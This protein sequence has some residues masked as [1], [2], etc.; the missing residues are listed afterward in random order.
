MM[1]PVLALCVSFALASPLHAAD[2]DWSRIYLGS[3][4]AVNADGSKFVFE[5]NDHL[6]IAPT[7]GGTARRLGTG[8]TYDSWPTMSPDGKRVAFASRRDGGTKVFEF[9]IEKGTVR[10][11]SYHS[12]TTWPRSWTPDG[13]RLLCLGYRDSSGPKTSL[14]VISIATGGREA[15]EILFDL[16]AEDPV[17]SP[18]GR[19]V[20]FV[21][22]GDELYR[23]RPNS[24]GPAAGQIWMFI[25]ATREFR[26]VVMHK[27]DCRNPLWR[28]DGRGFYYLDGRSG[29]RNVWYRD[30][31]TGEERALTKFAVDHVFQPSL[32]ADGRTMVFRQRF[33]FWRIDPTAAEP[34]PERILL[35]PEAG[36]IE[37]GKAKRRSYDSCWN[38]DSDGD[39]TFCDN[40]M[41]IAFTAGGDLYV[42]DTV[43]KEPTL[44][45]GD[46]ATHER[47]CVFAP[48]GKTLYYLSDRG[49]SS[50]VMKAIPADISKPW[51]E[52]SSF[53]KTPFVSTTGQRRMLS[54]SPDGSRLA[55][56]DPLGV[57]TFVDTNGTVLSRGPAATAG[58]G[59]AWSPDGRW[60]AAQLSDEFGNPDI[61]IISP[62]NAREPYDV[63]LNF[64]YDGDPAWSPDGKVL[65]FV[66]ER[67][68]LGDGKFLSYVY[69]DRVVE[70]VET[71]IKDLDRSRETIRDN[72]TDTNRYATIELPGDS[73]IRTD[74]THID[75]SDLH[76][77]VRTL[78]IHAALPFF[79]WDSRTLAFMNDS[80][81]T[82]TVR[83]P[84]RLTPDKLFNCWGYPRG[85]TRKGDRVLW[86]VNRLPAHGETQF[87]FS[88]YQNTDYEDY[89]ELA[90]RTAWAR[91]RDTY[92]DPAT[93]GVDWVNVSAR[94]LPA[95]RHA[96]S[97]SVFVRVMN[98]LLGELDSS[99]LGFY[100]DESSRREWIP[101]G[102]AAG[103]TE[104]TAHLGLR[105][106]KGGAKDGWVVRDVIPGGPADHLDI[107]MKA[108][109]VVTA[110][111]GR[112][113]CAGMDP[114]IVLNGPDRRKVRVTY[115]RKDGTVRTVAIKSVNYTEA[116]R[117]VG[118]EELK[119]K[120][121]IVH[122][123][124]GG[125]LGYLNVEAMNWESFWAFQHA[126]F[127]EGYGRDGLVIDVRNN[128]G[129]FTADQM[130]QIL[131][132]GDH[133]RS[134]TRTKGAGYLFGYWG[135][136]VWSKPIVVL[137]NE[138]TA[139]N[140]EIF[141]HAIKTLKRGK[142]VGRETG[143]G[144]IGTYDN[145]LL[146][147]GSFRDAR[148]GWFVLDGTDMEHHG[149]VPDVEV[150]DL[151]ADVDAGVDRQ[152]D[153]AIE[154][155]ADEVE[156]WKKA[157]P[158]VRFRFAR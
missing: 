84:D 155:L 108:G 57:F 23:K 146:D 52:N 4:P 142:L 53:V 88:V 35:R 25:P 117:L 93:H 101:K 98:M 85:W 102:E 33:D 22:R 96:Q 82:D 106:E 80:K 42:M 36:Y 61:W 40:G 1:R 18:D 123:K 37:R 147:M 125:R 47:E 119:A 97:Y 74:E 66:S 55:W 30:I 157:N 151:P 89:Q 109:D 2:E 104:V 49:D 7:T 65:A 127:S 115:A 32:S 81:G 122:E 6:W 103:W 58:G 9:D 116:R 158:P 131:L 8:D 156:A 148:F 78:R 44:V 76:D 64:K 59:Y 3:I 153:R 68:E 136:P 41:Q 110:I 21:R 15:E 145:P 124:S 105:Y 87:G 13:K 77:R 128:Y 71:D 91:I 14:R 28:P 139:S 111:D 95:A 69:L 107:G 118:E 92:Y 46:T 19:T 140:G 130:L 138:Y 73:M 51:W 121:R 17:T 150:D 134:V 56:Q 86:I 129:G 94:Y 114:T 154:V 143:G 16:P 34:T 26:C 54:I 132:G 149:A 60:V 120:R 20:L 113:V 10:Q 63:T 141:S 11:L 112:K 144:V 152:L 45:H 31:V 43:V 48:D 83:I 29:V 126:V 137:C 39:V 62:D 99:H 133:S 100:A 27:G 72:A 5:W 67:P 79:S 50:T 75:W 70:E 24:A 38:N 90:F 12:E 135:R